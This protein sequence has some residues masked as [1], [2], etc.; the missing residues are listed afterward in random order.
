MESNYYEVLGINK[1]ATEEEIKIA[2]K[3][4][5]KKYHP[6][7][8]GG[9]TIYEEHF[10]KINMAYQT[11]SDKNKRQ[12]YDWKLEYIS[13]RKNNPAT[14]TQRQQKRSYTPPRPQRQTKEQ[15][16]KNKKYII[17]VV[18]VLTIF[19]TGAILFYYY[20]NATL[21][22]KHLKKGI[23]WEEQ[24]NYLQ[25]QRHY[26]DALLYDKKLIEAYKRRAGIHLSIFK[27][28][29]S[30]LGD[31]SMAIKYSPHEDADLHFKRAK[32]LLK[33]KKY[34]EGLLDLNKAS[35][36]NPNFDSLYFYKG[37]VYNFIQKNYSEAIKNYNKALAITPAFKD[38]LLGMALS[39]QS[40][41]DYQGSIID[42]DKLIS[43]EQENGSYYYYRAYS[44]YYSNDTIGSC[45]DWFQ[46]ERLYFF[47]ARKAL[48][49]YCQ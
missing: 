30:A 48:N 19:L 46:A 34:D 29:H 32:C 11:L 33:I 41:L 28:Y 18:S 40:S 16:K 10:K 3:K 22:E 14:N 44:K 26:T 27:N 9:N 49:K 39:K 8:H 5:A 35:A 4:L 1:T 20:M 47:E 6:D 45:N 21:A 31:Y 17:I 25:A 38:A 7:K 24:K 43:L 42:F 13:Q 23:A 15:Q 12:R 37:E 36:L 2:F